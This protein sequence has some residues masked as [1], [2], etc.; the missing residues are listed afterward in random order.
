MKGE[1]GVRQHLV[2]PTASV[3]QSGIKV[4]AWTHRVIGINHVF[5]QLSG[6]AFCNKDGVVLK[7]SDM[8]DNIFH[9][10]LREIFDKHPGC[11]QSDIESI[12]DIEDQ[13]SVF[14][15]LRQGSCSHVIAMKIAEA[16]IKVPNR[17]S[18]KEAAGLGKM[19]MDVTQCHADVHVLLPSF[20]C[21]TV[22]M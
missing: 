17:W 20:V 2:L 9:K 1:H 14:R 4:Q 5:G 6:P 8:M 21:C 19:S 12:V 18:K 16:N 11:F 15:S 22:S 13:C 10:L 3:T 7:S